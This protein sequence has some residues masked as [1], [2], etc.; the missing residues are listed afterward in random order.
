MN[1]AQPWKV[2]QG[3]ERHTVGMSTVCSPDSVGMLEFQCWGF[4]T[5]SKRN[6]VGK[7][8]KDFKENKN[9]CST[10]LC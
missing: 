1:E 10:G 7:S 6:R 2:S 9:C 5:R 3:K 8:K 4:L